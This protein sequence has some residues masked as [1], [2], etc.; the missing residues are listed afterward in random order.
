MAEHRNPRP[1]DEDPL[2]D[3]RERGTA[4]EDLEDEDEDLDEEEDVDEDLPRGTM[5]DGRIEN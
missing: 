1:D 3:E 2:F 4:N 5:E